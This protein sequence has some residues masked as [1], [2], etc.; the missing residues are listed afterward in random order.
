MNG[1]VKLQIEGRVAH[2]IMDKPPDNRMDNDFFGC[3]KE[4]I[5]SIK[6]GNSIGV[7]LLYSSSKHFSAGADVE[8]IKRTIVEPW[9]DGVC[10]KEIVEKYVK[11]NGMILRELEMLPVPVIS[12][13]SGFCIGSGLELALA[14]DMR[15][16]SADAFFG[17]PEIS[18]GI[19]PGLGGSIRLRKLVGSNVTKEMLLAG[20]LMN[21][22]SAYEIGLVNRVVPKRREL[23]QKIS[24]LASVLS[25][26]KRFE[27][28]RYIKRAANSYQKGFAA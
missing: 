21:A 15:I 8:H 13:I 20:E 23:F 12:S 22:R 17:C 26:E 6:E 3:L 27:V 25:E 14:C 1:P 11:H 7:V 2:L 5:D 16:C 9:R 10:K 19:I 4:R 28:N 24:S 18:F